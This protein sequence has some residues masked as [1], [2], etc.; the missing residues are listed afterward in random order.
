[1]ELRV[2]QRIED[3]EKDETRRTDDGGNDR[4][5]REDLLRVAGIVR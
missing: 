5:D 4:A 3:C 1:M 2:S